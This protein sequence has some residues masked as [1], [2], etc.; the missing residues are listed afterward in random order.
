M[1]HTRKILMI[2]AA[3]VAVGAIAYFA[4]SDERQA[5]HGTAAQS[6]RTALAERRT[7]PI[8]VHANGYVTAIN[9]VDVR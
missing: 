8:T 3:L 9:T 4:L 5:I 2:G 7:I 1:Q 6:V